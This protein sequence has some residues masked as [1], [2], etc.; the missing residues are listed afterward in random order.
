MA[1]G[2]LDEAFEIVQ[3]RDIREH[4]RGQKLIGRLAL[5]FTKRGRENLEAERIQHA[6][7]DCNKAEKL[8]G[9]TADVAKLR[10]AICSE[11]EQK[12]LR[13]RHRSL[14]VAQ[15]RQHI[16]NGWISAGEEILKDS[17]DENGQAGVVL[18]QAAVARLRTSEAITKAQ[19]ALQRNDLDV[20]I[21]FVLKAGAAGSQNEQ[22]VELISKIR[23]LAA[24]QIKENFNS[25]RLDLAQSLWQ[26]VSP[27]TDGCSEI[28]EL[29]SALS[30]CSKA[31]EYVAAGRPREAVNLLRKVK[32]TCPSAKWLGAVTEQS[33][34]AAELLDELAASPLGLDITRRQ[35]M[36]EAIQ[37]TD[38]EKLIESMAQPQ[39][40]PNNRSSDNRAESSIPSKFVMQIDGIGSFYVL[41]DS[42]ITVGPVSSSARPTVGLMVDPNL[43]AVTIERSEDDYFIKSSSPIRVNDTTTTDKLLVDSDRISLSPRCVLKFNIPNPASTT[44]TLSLPSV[45]LGRADV[46]RIILM[47]RDILIGPNEGSHILAESLDETIALFAQNGRLLCRAKD[48]I[49]VDEKT[50]SSTAGLP[51]D[52]QISI[53]Q[54]SLV[55][56]EFKE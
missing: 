9:N 2:R 25:G 39:A 33:R 50:V 34:Q 32:L 44:A 43:P 19:N 18:Q 6:L 31:A 47:D 37:Q 46:R 7:A 29:G 26:R 55:L 30:Q 40:K 12:R 53:G 3:S 42:S 49:L 16:Q 27:I 1:D 45:R 23:S 22:V 35:D 4:R 56:T 15:A 17:D 24:K 5:A 36:E 51:L 48:K 52:R 21:D 54:I 41:R 11:M 38:N 10:S 20:A 14:K 13:S 28:S 8:A